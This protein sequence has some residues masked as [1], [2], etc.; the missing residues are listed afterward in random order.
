M[1]VNVFEMELPKKFFDAIIV[2]F[3]LAAGSSQEF[4][5]RQIKRM[6]I[7]LKSEGVL[8]LAIMPVASD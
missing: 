2:F 7:W 5:W 6:F 1:K 3:S 4:I 8:V